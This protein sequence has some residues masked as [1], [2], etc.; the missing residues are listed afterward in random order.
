MKQS[1][2]LITI[3]AIISAL[4]LIFSFKYAQPSELIRQTAGGFTWEGELDPNEF[5]EWPR[6]AGSY[7]MINPVIGKVTVENPDKNSPIQRIQILIYLPAEKLIA[8]RYFKEGKIYIYELDCNKNK[9]VR[10][11]L[12]TEEKQGCMKCHQREL[13]TRI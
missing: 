11:H 6:D 9:Y 4:I 1:L 10:R 5:V 12:T 7:R 13:K 8:Y 3:I 2:I